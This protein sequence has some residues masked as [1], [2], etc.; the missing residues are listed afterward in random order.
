MILDEQHRAA[1]DGYA[2]PLAKLEKSF[3]KAGLPLTFLCFMDAFGNKM[4]RVIPSRSNQKIL[5]IEGDNPAQAVK[6]VAAG[7]RL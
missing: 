7:V 2:K 6:D 3:N 5:C 4:V 1:F